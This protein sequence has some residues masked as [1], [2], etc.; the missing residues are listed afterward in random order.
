[1]RKNLFTLLLWLL[2]FLTVGAQNKVSV[3]GVVKSKDTGETLIGATVVVVGA[4]Q[5]VATDI[6]GRYSITVPVGSKLNY[7]Y[8]GYLPKEVT[9]NRGGVVNVE[10]SANEVM[11]DEVVAIG[12][13]SLKKSDLTGAVA[14]VSGEQLKM[15]PVSGIDQALQG[16]IAG[17]T[18]NSNSGQPGVAAEVRIRGIGTINADASPLYVVDGVIVNDI[19][20]LSP[21]DIQ[22]T[23]VLKDASATAIYGSRG[24]NGVILISTKRGGT[25]G[26]ANITFETYLGFQSRW[27]KLDLMGRDEFAHIKSIFTGSEEDLATDFNLWVQN[28]F[29]GRKSD[30]FPQVKTVSYPN[31]FDYGTT[32]TDWQ[33][34]VFQKNALMQNYYLSIDGGNEKG[35]YAI[36]ANYFNQKGTIIG[37]FYKRLTLRM[38][39]SYQVRKWLKIGENLSYMT[40]S[41][42]NAQNNNANSSVLSSAI[43]MAPWDPVTYPV[44]T[45][46]YPTKEYP[47]G[48]DL[49]GQYSASSNFK[50]V[51]NPFSMVYNSFPEHLSDRWVGDIYLEIVPVK[52]L[53]LRGDASMDMA[54]NRDKEFKPQYTISSYDKNEKNFLSSSM[55]RYH[56]MVYEGT[57]TYKNVF[58]GKHDLNVMFGV[59][60]EQYQ[61]NSL[62]GSGSNIYN[63]VETNWYLGYTREKNDTGEGVNKSR[64]VSFLGRLHYMFDNKYLATVNFRRDGS[65]KF[66]R[67][68]LWA[69]FPSVALAWKISE[70]NFFEPARNTID[71]LKLRLG[72]G[73]IGNDKI[74]DNLFIPTMSSAGPTF[75]DYVLGTSQALVSGATMLNY[76]GV[77]KWET[78]E[79]WN[80]GVDFGLFNGM[81][82]GSVD[83]FLKDTKDMLMYIK[84]PAHLGFRYDI[85]ANAGTVRN[86]GIE[87]SLEHKNRVGDFSYSV[88]GNVSFI[89]NELTE[90]NGGDK[91]WE[92]IDNII[93]S[94]RGLALRS[95]WGYRY[96]GVF[97]TKEEVEAYKNADGELIQPNSKAGDARYIDLNKDGKIDE[98]DRECLGNPFPWVTYGLNL[99]FEYRG[100]DLQLFFQGVAGNKIYNAMR[101][102]TEGKGEDATLSTA[103]RD[104]WSES[105]PNG[106]I[107][108]P[109]GN[110]MNF[111]GSDRFLENGSYLRLKNAQL[112]Y[113]F[114]RSWMSRL[115]VERLRLYLACSNLFTITKY[116]G[117]DPE[118][119]G[120]VDF[121][122]Y[123][124]ARTILVGAQINF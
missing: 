59:T 82:S 102:R 122:N 9:I 7:A 48:R 99:S 73:Q 10:L 36:S 69:S 19:N 86:K 8:L 45:V 13:G 109:Y 4:S 78:T 107:P 41:N 108:N 14:S 116:T 62:S 106:S 47:N 42:R 56:T 94:D 12:Y 80:I 33:D 79:Q 120:G 51:V 112:G 115:S 72:W 119:G 44:G 24:A 53:V 76:P 32:D 97:R 114:P 31:G 34:E 118:I 49:S 38:N 57:A 92:N 20:F 50:N 40:S 52:G 103:M 18:V 68:H 83:A 93:L 81:L 6:D 67:E 22:S 60:T 111:Y 65:S 30:Y 63:P 29:T 58:A 17:V 11:L 61:Y 113:T 66:P 71:F 121:G 15:S 5:G 35:N 89:H 105:N 104:M 91:I 77:G 87:I 26:N 3:S 75:I 1:M 39:S 123:P 95:F 84:G 46:S 54:F 110:S 100:F 21:S 96:D 2:A 28:Y 124:Q 55:G 27:K 70:E 98:N 117:Y 101:K 88:N 37:S 23:E 64:R 43:A 90:L 85:M 74:G 25:D 16:R